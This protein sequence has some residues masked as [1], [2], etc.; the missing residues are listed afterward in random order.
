MNLGTLIVT[1]L[2]FLC[3]RKYHPAVS[4][5]YS[6]ITPHNF[7]AIGIHMTLTINIAYNYLML[8][9]TIFSRSRVHDT[10][11]MPTVEGEVDCGE[12]IT[13]SNRTEVAK[14]QSITKA[15]SLNL[16]STNPV[17]LPQFNKP[18]TLLDVNVNGNDS[19]HLK[20]PRI[21]KTGVKYMKGE[22][23]VVI[24][25]VLGDNRSP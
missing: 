24:N 6:S 12:Q 1:Q 17:T 7:L 20:R 23:K 16:E 10:K 5:D 11:I 9:L 2:I 18:K 3:A 19:L 14:S 21:V 25:P 15:T 13:K 22:K 8:G 4:L